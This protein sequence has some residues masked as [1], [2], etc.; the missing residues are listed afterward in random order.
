M[1]IMQ[2]VSTLGPVVGV[3]LV[4]AMAVVPSI[5]DARAGSPERPVAPPPLVPRHPRPGQPAQHRL[6]GHRRPPLDL[7]A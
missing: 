3:A 7:A 2:L 6:R 4:G 1:D 5:M